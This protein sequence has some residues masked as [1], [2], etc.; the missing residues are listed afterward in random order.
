LESLNNLSNHF[1]IPLIWGFTV[2]PFLLLA[3]L[4]YYYPLFCMCKKYGKRG[5]KGRRGEEN[6]EREKSTRHNK[7]VTVN[8]KNTTNAARTKRTSNK[9]NKK[10][11]RW[12]PTRTALSTSTSTSLHWPSKQIVQPGIYLLLYTEKKIKHFSM[13]EIFHI[14]LDMLEMW[15]RYQYSILFLPMV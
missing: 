5:A 11:L 13:I 12:P 7:T 4:P 9:N 15:I 10:M 1:K 2:F 6:E 14:I 3:N 8:A